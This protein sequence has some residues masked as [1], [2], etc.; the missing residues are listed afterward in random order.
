MQHL[1]F[2]TDNILASLGV[3]KGGPSE[4]LDIDANDYDNLFQCP[5]NL[6]E[7]KECIRA[8]HVLVDG[9]Q[10]GYLLQIFT[11]NI[12]GPIFVETIQ[13]ENNPSFGE[14]NFGA[15]FRSIEKDRERRGVI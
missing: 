4:M 7:D 11:K 13:R 6:R 15:L 5:P 9:D 2:S 12:I 1:A 8:H 3:M 10:D 14:G